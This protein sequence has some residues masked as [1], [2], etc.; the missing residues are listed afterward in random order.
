LKTAID[1]LLLVIGAIA[2]LSGAFMM[3]AGAD[4][5]QVERGWAHFIAGAALFSGGLVAVAIVWSAIRLRGSLS[6]AFASAP[7]DRFVESQSIDGAPAVEPAQI[8]T[9]AAEATVAAIG[10]T[11]VAAVILSEF[12][13][14]PKAMEHPDEPA[15]EEPPSQPKKR[16]DP[17]GAFSRA[18]Q[19]ESE[20]APSPVEPLAAPDV[21]TELPGQDPGQDKRPTI[22]DLFYNAR[23]PPTPAPQPDFDLGLAD[24]LEPPTPA[25]APSSLRLPE[26]SAETVHIEPEPV[27]EAPGEEIAAEPAPAPAPSKPE[28]NEDDDWL[29][30]T[31]RA[32]DLELGRSTVSEAPPPSA[33]SAQPQ[34]QPADEEARLEAKVI[35]RYTSGDTNYVMFSDGS[36]EAQTPD[37]AMRFGS[38]IELR[39]FVEQRT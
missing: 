6:E 10:T 36:I 19:A 35:G 25:P 28:R 39:R 8:H 20:V 29:A 37:G 3:W 33:E 11:A 34:P 4:I 5:I 32:L 38:L 7:P 26:A 1:W 22:D 18:R 21:K 13:T 9:S 15:P 17:F 31:A 24:A 12:E 14:P 16:F 23:T 30:E 27:P 2:A